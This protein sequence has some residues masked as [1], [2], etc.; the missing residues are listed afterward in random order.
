MNSDATKS[1]GPEHITEVF[2][3]YAQLMSAGD[4]EGIV[5]L[6]ASDAVMRDPVTGPA[7]RGHD[8]IRAWYQKSFDNNGGHIDM[9]LD[10]AV[11]VAGRSG[12]AALTAVAGNGSTTIRVETLDVMEFDDAGL[13]V[14]MDAYWGPTN[15]H[16]TAGP[17]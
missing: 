14:R 3:Q 5:A 1:A 7:Y 13:I 10:G 6:Y 16:A 15:V 11:R 8:E 4:T 17:R 12:A 2:E 9:T